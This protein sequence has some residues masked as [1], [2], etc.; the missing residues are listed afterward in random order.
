V[1]VG[2]S[3]LVW[4]YPYI[5]AALQRTSSPGAMAMSSLDAVEVD[6]AVARAPNTQSG[7]LFAGSTMATA[8]KS[9]TGSKQ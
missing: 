6:H 4:S 2:L 8:E 5:R 9:T 1:A 3:A 7:M